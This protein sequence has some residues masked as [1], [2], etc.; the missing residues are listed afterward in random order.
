MH[1]TGSNGSN[2]V[3]GQKAIVPLSSLCTSHDYNIWHHWEFLIVWLLFEDGVWSIGA[4]R[5][6]HTRALPGLFRSIRTLIMRTRCEDTR[7]TLRPAYKCAFA[8][9]DISIAYSVVTKSLPQLRIKCGITKSCPGTHTALQV[10]IWSDRW[11]RQLLT[12][13]MTLWGGREVGRGSQF[14]F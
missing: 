10:L 2:G 3:A 7:H 12:A 4:C 9:T 1:N 13:C 11:L 5:P 6:G 14:F 8:R